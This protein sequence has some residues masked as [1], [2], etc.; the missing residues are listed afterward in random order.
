MARQ[1]YPCNNPP[2]ICPFL[3]NDFENCRSYCGIGVD[4]EEPEDYEEDEEE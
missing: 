4:E 3:E 1:F 2:F